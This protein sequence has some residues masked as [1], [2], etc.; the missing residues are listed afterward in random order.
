LAATEPPGRRGR[1]AMED[2]RQEH[3]QHIFVINGAP[4]F[5]DLVR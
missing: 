5:L 1:A 3:R 4:E 2:R